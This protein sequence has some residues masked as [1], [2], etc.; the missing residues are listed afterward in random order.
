MK[1]KILKL[2]DDI[3]ILKSSLNPD[4]TL[5]GN[6]YYLNNEEILSGQRE[7]GDARYPYV[8]DGR[9]LWAHASGHINAS[10]SV[11][12]ILSTSYFNNEPCMDFWGG[13][14][15]ENN[16][17]FPISVLGTTK[18]L[19]EPCS[20][21]RYT[22][23]APRA[24]YYIAETQDVIFAVRAHITSK[25]QLNFTFCAINK[26]DNVTEIYLASYMDFR[27]RN[28]NYEDFWDCMSRN[29]KLYENGTY[30][31]STRQKG[32]KVNYFAVVNKLIESSNPP[33]VESTVSKEVFTGTSSN[34]I[35]NA[36]SLKTG[37]FFRT[38][39]K[40]YT[41]YYPVLSDIIKTSVNPKDIA[42]VNYLCNIVSEKEEADLLINNEVDMAELEA[43]IKAQEEQESNLFS[44]IKLEFDKTKD[45]SLNNLIFNRFLKT[46]QKQIDLVA[47]GKNWASEY[48]GV[49]DV[50][51]QLDT[52]LLW[53]PT[54]SRKK[55]VFTL[56][57]IMSNG[58]SP[59]Q[60]SVPVNK[61]LIPE[62]DM[63]EYI[64]QG[65][66]IIDV[67]YDYICFTGDYSI[68]SE[69][70]YYYE[71]ISEEKKEFKRC[72]KTSVLEHLVRI[73]DYLISN[74]DSE[75]NCLKI[76]YGDWNDAANGLGTTKDPDKEFGTGVS[77]MAS[78]QFYHNL[79]EL[80]EILKHSNEYENKISEYL[81][82][83]E[84]LGD[85]LYKYAV[86]NAPDNTKHIIHGWGDRKSYDVGSVRD[87]DGK[88]RYSSTANAFWCISGLINKDKTL[89]SAV[90]EAYEILNSKYGVRTFV[91]YFEPVMRPEVGPIASIVPG[92]Y[93][94]GCSYVHSV[95]FFAMALFVIGE[96]KKAWEQIIKAMPITHSFVTKTP[97]VMSNSFCYNE[98]AELD[99]ESMGDWYT[100]SAPTLYRCLVK[101]AL[102]IMPTLEGIMI[103]PSDYMVSDNISLVMKIKGADVDFIYQNKGLGKRTFYVNG[104]E[105]AKE[106]DDVSGAEYIRIGNNDFADKL[107]IEIID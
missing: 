98:E 76:L 19:F 50:I 39:R 36:L 23:F 24:A 49:R 16:E 84:K 4:N 82:I 104:V 60:F 7:I 83:R 71:M 33:V 96:G 25:K 90:L 48:L 3:K 46:L 69:E 73:T 2:L 37:E 72:E 11:L 77:V 70:C 103:K 44:N 6:T 29:G 64:D 8:M 10:E 81:E 26:S 58:R 30:L 47:L 86:Q 15:T 93:E 1:E 51:Q 68:L 91:P 42:F 59:R 85:G 31:F 101:Y 28:K 53:N 38:Q 13:F 18:Q 57:H 9:I 66:W 107:K 92:T 40:A 97:F 62:F 35:S 89:K 56:N 34:N 22:V 78:L 5:P 80:S 102:G 88:R 100:G 94:N 20:V 55:I 67:V 43:D 52:S 74:I 65:I 75:T 106:I 12:T 21:E 87:S 45:K 105:Y 99:G 79:F 32:G 41:A 27:L 63:R 17:W 95:I 61:E 14:K 54:E